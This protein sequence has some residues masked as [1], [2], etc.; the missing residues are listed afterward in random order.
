MINPIKH[1]VKND[2]DYLFNVEDNLKYDFIKL[3]IYTNNLS[4]RDMI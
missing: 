2:I 3:I 1:I 4:Y